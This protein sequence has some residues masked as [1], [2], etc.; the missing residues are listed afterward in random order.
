MADKMPDRA[1]EEFRL[2][3]ATAEGPGMKL[4]IFRSA[5]T[6]A[7]QGKIAKIG[8]R[9]ASKPIIRT[10]K[11]PMN[12]TPKGATVRP[13]RAAALPGNGK[14]AGLGSK[15]ARRPVPA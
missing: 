7:M 15:G 6:K 12:C 13:W 10:M 9:S 2:K 4:R 14:T 5:W 11:L 3:I 1:E 8:F